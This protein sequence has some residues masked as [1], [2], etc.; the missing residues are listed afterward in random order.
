[1][2]CNRTPVGLLNVHS[3][4]GWSQIHWR[5]LHGLVG[6]ALVI[7]FALLTFPTVEIFRRVLLPG[8]GELAPPV[9]ALV[10][11][12]T[13]GLIIIAV[14]W[15]LAVRPHEASVSS[16]GLTWPGIP[17]TKPVPLTIGVIVVGLS[18]TATYSLLTQNYGPDI[19]VPP[20]QG[21][22]VLPGVAAWLTFIVLALWTPLTEEIFFRGFVFSGLKS[23]WGTRWAV[24]ISAA[25]FSAFH[26][27]P[28]VV[29]PIFVS[30]L[31]FAWLYHR[32]GTLWSTITAHAV[33]NGLVVFATFYGV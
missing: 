16:L 12:L 25:I 31:L 33:Q 26:V 24:L 20:D 2:S 30:G 8:E 15:F 13:L 9:V 5:G 32:T 23:Q 22:I 19:L 3:D 29:I 1:M 7:V 18:F 6:I 11:S 27:L 17:N 28:A 10:T 14:V 21:D 4:Q